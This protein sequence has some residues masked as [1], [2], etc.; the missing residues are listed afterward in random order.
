MHCKFLLCFFRYVALVEV[1]IPE[2]SQE[3]GFKKVISCLAGWSIFTL[4][5]FW[6]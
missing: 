3:V 5:A 4:L 1:L 6:V 2:F